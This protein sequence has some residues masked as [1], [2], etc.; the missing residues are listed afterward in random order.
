MTGQLPYT[1]QLC[2]LP[3]CHL[4]TAA[5]GVYCLTDPTGAVNISC[6]GYENGIYQGAQ[7]CATACLLWRLSSLCMLDTS[8]QARWSFSVSCF[9]LQTFLPS[10]LRCSIAPSSQSR[11][12]CVYKHPGLCIALSCHSLQGETLH[13]IVISLH[14][15]LCQPPASE[16]V[17]CRKRQPFVQW[18]ESLQNYRVA[19]KKVI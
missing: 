13:Y 2:L 7:N 17:G 6:Y 1:E 8:C 15:Y 10:S 3:L 9:R 19:R 12:E 16:T 11:L 18:S 4:Y 14:L 5:S